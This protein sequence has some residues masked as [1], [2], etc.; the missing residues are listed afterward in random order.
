[1]IIKLFAGKLY[2][3]NI[4]ILVYIMFILCTEP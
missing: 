4:E 2:L 3:F 1:M